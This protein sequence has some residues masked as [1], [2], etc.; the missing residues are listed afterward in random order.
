MT[1]PK[2]KPRCTEP[3]LSARFCFGAGE[4]KPPLPTLGFDITADFL[5]TLRRLVADFVVFR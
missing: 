2:Q 4:G 1:A 5:A 3:L